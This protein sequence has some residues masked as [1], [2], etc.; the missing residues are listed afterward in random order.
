LPEDFKKYGVNFKSLE[1][2]EYWLEAY[3]F[4]TKNIKNI[5]PLIDRVQKNYGMDFETARDSILYEV[6]NGFQYFKSNIH[7]KQRNSWALKYIVFFVFLLSSGLINLLISAFIKKH[8]FDILYEEMW[9]QNSLFS[10][11]YKY[12]DVELP[13]EKSRAV[14]FDHPAPAKPF[15]K[16]PKISM[17]N[18]EVIN[19]RFGAFVFDWKEVLKVILKD[20]FFFLKLWKLSKNSN[21]TYIYF[22]FLRKFLL[23]KTQVQKVEAKNLIMAGDYYW[24]P[25]KYFQ[26]KKNIQNILLIQHNMKVNIINNTFQYSDFHFLHSEDAIKNMEFY[27]NSQLLAVGSFQLIPFLEKVKQEYDIL[28]INQTI[29]DNLKK[30]YPTL[31]QEKLQQEHETLIENFHKYLLE[32]PSLKV[33]Y[34]AKPDYVTKEPFMSVEKKMKDLKNISFIGAYGFDMFEIIQK[35]KIII[36]MYSS[37]GREAYGLDK[38]VLWVN[39]NKVCSVFKQGV[40]AEDL[41][42][43]LNNSY[44]EF[45]KKVD[46]LLSGNR[47][48]EKHFQKLKQEYMNI[49]E[50][51]AKVLTNYLI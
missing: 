6:I 43:I 51:P 21:T 40:D 8:K 25:I 32:N 22:R 44:K 27:G 20:S 28:F 3:D 30:N 5:A 24:N 23:Y 47:E 4:Y 37:V 11:F 42:V 36:N 7:S 10:R 49:N 17:W 19:R 9:E 29:F 1:N 26:F 13:K 38:P 41:H 46:L 18:D 35:S 31:S 2:N 45:R 39:Y 15:F 34:V 50:N 16:K 48:V 12:I 33:I 14:L